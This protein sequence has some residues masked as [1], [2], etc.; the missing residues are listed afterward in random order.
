[1]IDISVQLDRNAASTARLLDSLAALDEPAVAGP[2]QLPGWNRAQLI[3]HLA[4]NAD[5]FAGMYAAARQGVVAH[6]YPH[7]P[8]GR[9]ADIDAGRDRPAAAVLADVRSSID[10]LDAEADRLTPDQ[11]QRDGEV[12]AGRLAVWETLPARRREVEVHHVDLGVG[13]LPADWPADFV[14][15]ELAVQGRGLSSR[16]EGPAGL[17]LVTAEGEKWEAGG[18]GGPDAPV[19]VVTG[20]G[21]EILA[22]LLGRPSRLD[23]PPTIRSWQ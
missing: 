17:C 3:T 5:G 19:T 8:A 16:V 9:A 23:H 7:G 18:A 15:T 11:W 20:P 6:Q 14:S 1:M 21:A 22:W 13:Y 4:R 12:F 2:S 10:R